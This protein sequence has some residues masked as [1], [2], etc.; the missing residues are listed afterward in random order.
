[1]SICVF[2]SK[3]YYQHTDATSGQVC[4]KCRDKEES[5]QAQR[6]IYLDGQWPQSEDNSWYQLTDMLRVY[7]LYIAKGRPWE[8]E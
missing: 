6:Q 1:M 2:C 3:H 4:G 7:K 5:F 8:N